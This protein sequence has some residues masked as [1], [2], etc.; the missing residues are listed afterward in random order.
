MKVNDF[1]FLFDFCKKTKKDEKKLFFFLFIFPAI[2]K[3]LKSFGIESF[4]WG[5][6]SLNCLMD[7]PNIKTES[8][9]DAVIVGFDEHISYPKMVKAATYLRNEQ[10]PFI[11]TN[12][13]ENFPSE[14]NVYPGK[15]FSPPQLVNKKEN[16]F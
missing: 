4:G 12:T 14:K 1:Y 15:K 6:D 8:D 3:E 9:V 5:S 13:D 11:A 7:I 16:F 10:I 2:G